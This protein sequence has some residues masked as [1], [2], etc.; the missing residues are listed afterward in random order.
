MTNKEATCAAREAKRFDDIVSG[1][2][3]VAVA[4]QSQ[5]KQAQPNRKGG[6][7]N[8]ED[9]NTMAA[10]YIR[11]VGI[12]LPGALAKLSELKDPRN[13]KKCDHSLPTLIV[14]G[15]IMF[16]SNMQSRRAANQDISGESAHELLKQV[17]PDLA[18]IPHADTL[19]RL[20]KRIDVDGI[21]ACYEDTITTFINSK[22]FLELN[23]GRCLIAIDGTQKY[24]RRY[25][26]D[27]HALVYNRGNEDR[28]RYAVYVLESIL[29]LDNGMILPLFTEFLKNDDGELGDEAKKQDCELKAFTR[30]TD[31]IAKVIGKGRVTLLMDGLYANGPVV[32]R[33]KAFGWD[34][35]INLK[36]GSLQTVWEDFDGLCKCAPENT[37][38]NT[39]AE[40]RKQEFHWAN[41][42]EYIYG[43]NHKKIHLNV[44]TCREEWIEMHLHSDEKPKAMVCEYAW[45]SSKVWEILRLK[46]I[47]QHAVDLLQDNPD[48]RKRGCIYRDIRLRAV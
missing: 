15:L 30:L 28:E 36:R 12:L 8:A 27:E 25:C 16:L 44:V 34:F 40:E 23:P 48:G 31:K 5:K 42:I 7:L 43:K 22:T 37:L 41:E 46:G 4:F 20:L 18:T 3:K 11:L 9:E 29:I 2:H 19:A 32:S 24:S 6:G 14:Y 39:T 38:Q 1:R 17:I 45:L 10:D 33:C 21:E 35:M 26:F 13:V 47:G